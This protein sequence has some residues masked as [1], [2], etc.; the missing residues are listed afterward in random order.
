MLPKRK[1][2][3]VPADNPLL[4]AAFVNHWDL[5][6]SFRVGRRLS[7][8]VLADYASWLRAKGINPDTGRMTPDGLAFFESLIRAQNARNEVNN[9]RRDRP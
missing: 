4:R 9:A 3:R 2:K 7:P 5:H 8:D 1:S 6:P